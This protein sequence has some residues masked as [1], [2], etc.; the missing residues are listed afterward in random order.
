[1]SQ[2]PRSLPHLQAALS[3]LSSMLVQGGSRH[4]VKRS[5]PITEPTATGIAGGAV[6]ATGT[7]VGTSLV[8]DPVATTGPL[9]PTPV[10]TVIQS[11]TPTPSLLQSADASGVTSSS[12][13]KSIP[14]GAVI[15]SCI[16]AFIALSIFI[17]LII[18]FYRRHSAS[19]KK[20][21]KVRG[22]L[23]HDRNLETDKQRRRSR[24]ESWKKLEEGKDTHQTKEVDQVV[25]MEK[26]T[27]FKRAASVRT[28]YTQKS[29]DEPPLTYPRSFAPFDTNL[30]RKLSADDTTVSLPQPASNANSTTKGQTPSGLSPSNTLG[31]PLSSLNMAIPTPEATVLKPHKWESAEVV[32]YAEGQS[33][34]VVEPSGQDKDGRSTQN[35]FFGSQDYNRS[36]SNPPSAKGK[37]HLHDSLISSVSSVDTQLPKPVFVHHQATDSSTSTQSKD[38]ALQ[39]LIV[40]LD[41]PE[42]EVR[43]RLRVA[44][45][46][47]S[48]ISQSSQYGSLSVDEE[49]FVKNIHL[50]PPGGNVSKF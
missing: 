49:E 50:P 46:Q 32:H 26:L 9:P 12:S 47:P 4:F 3:L 28:A 38:R 40:A 16:G 19:L 43:E 33:A 22:P 23:T 35:P 44:S 30:V 21:A 36:I 17:I 10:F 14:L 31:E 5:D 18:W 39:A 27:M 34:Q 6:T 45:M 7:I 25:P 29:V 15:G 2:L 37:E 13:S 20:Q 42:D 1:M 11:T 48:F 41:L 8:F 24:L